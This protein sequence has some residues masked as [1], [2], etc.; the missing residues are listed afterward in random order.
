VSTGPKLTDEDRLRLQQLKLMEWAEGRSSSKDVVAK[1]EDR[2]IPV[3]NIADSWNLTQD[4]DLS[5]WQKSARDSWFEAGRRGTVKVVT[6]AGKTVL[7]MAIA[8]RLQAEDPELRVAIVV[9][10]IVL[11]NQWLDVFQTHSNLPGSLIGRLGGGHTD[12][13]GDG[14]RVLVCV[15][16]SARRLLAKDVAQA[17]IKEHLLLIA[18]ECH[19]AGAPEMS[20]VLE[21]G[22]RYSLGLS[23]TPER[24]EGDGSN[25]N[26]EYEDSN[27]GKALG[28]IIYEMT[29]SDAIELGVLPRFE[30]Q[31]Y[32]LSLDPGEANRYEALSRSIS[33]ARKELT[34]ASPSA[35]NAGPGG[36]TGWARR[37]AA[38]GGSPLSGLATK[39]V[40]DT[41]RRKQLLYRAK[42]RSV[43]TLQLVRGALESRPDARVI[44]FHESI[45]EVISIFETLR[46]DGIPA[47]MEHSELP[48][49]LRESTLELFRSGSA[50]VVVSARSLIEGFNVPEADLG[51]I[52]ASSSSPRQRIQSIGRVLRTHRGS[53]G[54]EKSSRVCMLY[55]RDSVDEGIYEKAD[56]DQ[57]V[58]SDRNRYFNW[59][60]P[61]API[62]QPGPPR[63]S[64]PNETEID[65][66][67][68]EFG[69]EYSGRYE[70]TEYSTDSTGNIL[71]SDGKFVANPQEIPSLVNGLKGR[72]GR[73]RVTSKKM[74]VLVRVQSE[75]DDWKTLFGG[76]IPDPFEIQTSSVATGDVDV[77]ELK[78]GDPYPGPVEPA[79][80]YKFRQRSGGI[81]AK[82]VRGGEVFAHGASADTLVS[83]LTEI[84][85]TGSPVSKVFL[86]D[87][88]HVFWRENGLARFI[89]TIA[90][91]LQ[92]PI[93]EQHE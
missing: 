74:A 36:L 22:R 71:D 25:Q 75:P 66:D 31:H 69:D 64:L 15:L 45:D 3:E 7:A 82:R 27:L 91:A 89:G 62:E 13:F 26:T 16:A 10:T 57:L 79:T 8:E 58:G 6:G 53:E 47:V 54:D 51:I 78:I 46:N 14:R 2:Q 61:M 38:R 86:N 33:D 60:P 90:E 73:F 85:R 68:L 23:A 34:A 59:D 19:R 32:G 40:N 49:S 88:D 24:D 44:L 77:T 50:K 76:I 87:L 43:A 17:E 28:K 92:F 83:A 9:P 39:F 56:W 72:P 81:L 52:V 18:D 12:N 67:L 4:L 21:T 48:N 80:E 70:G 84:R 37:T 1:T 29:F 30:L 35:R 63:T 11:M 65:F 20:S 42:S 5:P 93:E 41:N 55:I